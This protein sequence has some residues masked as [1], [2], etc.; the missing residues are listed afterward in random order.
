MFIVRPTIETVPLSLRYSRDSSI[1]VMACIAAVHCQPLPI[2][3][4]RRVL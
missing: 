1:T 4:K 3:R 2:R